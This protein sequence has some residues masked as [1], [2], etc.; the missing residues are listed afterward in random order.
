[1]N[2]YGYYFDTPSDFQDVR[3]ESGIEG[4]NKS[5]NY[6]YSAMFGRAYMIRHDDV[7]YIIAF[8]ETCGRLMLSR[9]MRSHRG[10]PMTT[11]LIY[12]MLTQKTAGALCTTPFRAYGI[13]IDM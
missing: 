8:T 5:Y 12:A 11:S 6:D 3:Y 9:A 13:L 2:T 4:M 10:I 1:E 7:D